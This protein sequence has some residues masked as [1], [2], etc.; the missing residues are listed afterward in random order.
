MLRDCANHAMGRGCGARRHPAQGEE[1]ANPRFV[2][3]LH[4]GDFRS[5]LR[6]C[7]TCCASIV[8]AF[9]AIVVW[10]L[11]LCG[12]SHRSYRVASLAVPVVDGALAALCALVA[13]VTP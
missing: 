13:P 1:E 4:I 3:K 9:A 12:S 10:S 2:K 11:S 5:F 8:V 7:D 6:S